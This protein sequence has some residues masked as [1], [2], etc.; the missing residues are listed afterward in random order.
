MNTAVTQTAF[1]FDT[2][3]IPSIKRRAKSLGKSVN[4]YVLDLIEKDMAE[5]NML[6]KISL[7]GI[8]DENVERLSGILKNPDMRVVESDS[9]AK[10]IWER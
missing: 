2:Q 4:K 8:Y 9:R 3:L 6:P 10:A 1:K 7:D 5:A